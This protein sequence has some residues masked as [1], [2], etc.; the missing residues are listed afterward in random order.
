MSPLRCRGHQWSD[1]QHR[2]RYSR[3]QQASL[4]GTFQQFVGGLPVVSRPICDS[5]NDRL[6][7]NLGAQKDH[8]NRRALQTMVSEIRLVLGPR[9]RAILMF[10]WSLGPLVVPITYLE[11]SGASRSGLIAWCKGPF[12][13]LNRY[14]RKHG[15]AHLLSKGAA[16]FL[17][18]GTLEAHLR[19]GLVE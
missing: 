1:S 13:R 15:T 2:G 4:K 12:C 11:K 19:S 6:L 16:S 7:L 14:T 5:R 18:Q 9:L 10:M 3:R 17:N 8:I